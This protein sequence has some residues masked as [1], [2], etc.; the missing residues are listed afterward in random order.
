MKANWKNKSYQITGVKPLLM[1]N[2]QL[3][4]PF[5]EFTQKIKSLSKGRNKS[6]DTLKE[7][8]RLEWFG[9]LYVSDGKPCIPG[10]IMEAVMANAAKEIKKGKKALG[11]IEC[12]DN[13]PLEYDGPKD[14]EKLWG[15][16]NF[17]LSTLAVVDRKRILRTRPRFN[18]WKANIKIYYDA[19]V[20]NDS[21]IDQLIEIAGQKGLMDWRP[22]FGQFEV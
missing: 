7:L 6:D 15:D 5:N 9:G 19:T 2:D 17:R 16:Q 20:F 10:E 4:D 1:H 18:S 8:A 22:K 21:E 13:F 11:A 12:P 14:P 3:A